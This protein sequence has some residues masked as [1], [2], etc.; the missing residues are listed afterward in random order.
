MKRKGTDPKRA[1]IINENTDG[2]MLG[3][4]MLHYEAGHAL[5]YS[6]L[7]DILVFEWN[8]PP[9]VK[10]NGGYTEKIVCRLHQWFTPEGVDF[11]IDLIFPEICESCT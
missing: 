1:F 7:T 8:V 10:G 2:R 5:R 9:N 6:P 11:V 3:I 4:I